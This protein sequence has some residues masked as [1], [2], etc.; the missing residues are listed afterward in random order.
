MTMSDAGAI[1]GARRAELAGTTREDGYTYMTMSNLGALA[2]GRPSIEDDRKY[3]S[4]EEREF[5]ETSAN[6][7]LCHLH[8]KEERKHKREE[9]EVVFEKKCIM[10]TKI[11]KQFHCGTYCRPCHR[12]PAGK[13]H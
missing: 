1:G 8:Y 11:V 12:T 2:G 4:I 7:H 13:K 5:V 9:T 10:C 6:N 3:C